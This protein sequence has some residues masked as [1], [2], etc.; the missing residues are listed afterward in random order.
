MTIPE[1]CLEC[2]EKEQERFQLRARS[3]DAAGTKALDIG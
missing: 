1:S 2:E 3:T